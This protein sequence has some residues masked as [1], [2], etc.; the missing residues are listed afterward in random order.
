MKHKLQTFGSLLLLLLLWQ[1]LALW[2]N[3]SVI[4]PTPIEVIQKTIVLL[5][6]KSTYIHL[7]STFIRAHLALLMALVLSFGLA[8]GTMKVQWMKALFQPWIRILQ[9]IP[10]ISFIIL[11]MFI[12]DSKKTILWVVGFMIFPVAYH[13][14]SQGFN[15]IY[16]KYHKQIQLDKQPWYRNLYKIY[17]PLQK[18]TLMTLLETLIP[19]SLKITVMSEVLIYTTTGLGHILNHA[20]ANID[21]P[22][23][24]SY[25]MLLVVGCFIETLIVRQIT[26]RSV[27]DESSI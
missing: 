2:I 18:P 19:M 7:F 16:D 24:F 9:T 1:S 5:F 23:V 27:A 20:R 4:L 6:T 10:Q 11:L 14:F 21:M 13:S 22:L 12:T 3:R 15:A 26:K 17:M 25:T 8:Y